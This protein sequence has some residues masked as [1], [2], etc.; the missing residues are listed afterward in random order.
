MPG[1]AAAW[2]SLEVAKLIVGSL[3]PV[4]IFCAGLMVARETRRYED[5]QWV[6]RRLFDLRLDLWDGIGPPLNDLFCFF[7]LVGHFR[8]IEPPRVIQIKREVDKIVHSNTHVLGPLFM[9]RYYNL[10]AAC[11]TT[12]VG[13]GED[14][15]LRASISIQRRERGLWDDAW[16]RLFVSEREASP[17]EVAHAYDDLL[18]TFER[19][20]PDDGKRGS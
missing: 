16:N 15:K 20:S 12:F 5:R 2:N 18:S 13:A 8:A 9:E 14:A 11:F 6:Q 4:A 10:M 17:A 1:M 19:L 7:A 3:I